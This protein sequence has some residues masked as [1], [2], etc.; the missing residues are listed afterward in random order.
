[1]DLGIV[2]SLWDTSVYLEYGSVVLV[3][4]SRPG[5]NNGW[6]RAVIGLEGSIRDEKRMLPSG[7]YD[8]HPATNRPNMRPII[9]S[10]PE[11]QEEVVAALRLAY[12]V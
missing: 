5:T 8:K 7:N 10:I 6:Y 3:A 11:D 1:M 12:G 9:E 4:T 2:D